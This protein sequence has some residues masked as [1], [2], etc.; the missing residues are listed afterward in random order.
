MAYLGLETIR[1][2]TTGACIEDIFQLHFPQATL[3]ADLTWGKGRFWIWPRETQGWG[4][5]G[6]RH[7]PGATFKKIIRVVGLD[8]EPI[9]GCIQ[10]DY[11]HVPLKDKSVD[12]VVFDP[13][14]IFTR[15]VRRITG[16]KRGFLGAEGAVAKAFPHNSMELLQHT[17]RAFE[18]S[19]RIARQGMVL[20]GMDLVVGKDVNWWTFGVMQAVQDS[21]GLL[22]YDMLIQV[23]PAA[24]LKD[25]RWKN[26]YH[27]RRRHVV[28]LI[29]RW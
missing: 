5:I 1:H 24:R 8:I 4:L 20:K 15:G 6:D 22:P 9:A 11:L 23:S 14:F 18:E 10:S 29:Y 26:Q 17:L 13:P 25:P 12:V 21:W 27:F 7:D 16:T 19:R 2:G 3:V 28:Y